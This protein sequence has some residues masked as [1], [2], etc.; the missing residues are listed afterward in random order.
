M[1]LVVPERTTFQHILRL[2]NTNVDGRVKIQIA[3]TSVKGVGRRF[4]NIACK[5]ADIDLTKRAGE[6]SS[7][8]LERYRRRQV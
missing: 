8:E 2:L 1:S 5:K 3:L 7:E 6:L 4:A